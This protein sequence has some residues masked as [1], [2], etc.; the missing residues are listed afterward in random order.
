MELRRHTLIDTN[1]IP[2]RRGWFAYAL[3]FVIVFYKVIE[4]KRREVRPGLIALYRTD[5]MGRG[6]CCSWRQQSPA[7]Q[8]RASKAWSGKS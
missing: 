8:H 4:G 6:T 2:L 3:R 7:S 1:L 5:C